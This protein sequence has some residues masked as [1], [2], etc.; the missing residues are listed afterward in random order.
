[1]H[2]KDLYDNSVFIGP[3]SYLNIQAGF[4]ILYPGHECSY[5]EVLIGLYS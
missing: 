1:M 2:L 5:E 3:L 4:R